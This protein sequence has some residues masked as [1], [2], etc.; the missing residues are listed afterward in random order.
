MPSPP[1]MSTSLETE[2]VPNV[3][4][5][6]TPSC[7]RTLDLNYNIYTTS[8]HIIALESN[9][10]PI[11]LLHSEAMSIAT[12]IFSRSPSRFTTIAPDDN[13][14][15]RSI[16]TAKKKAITVDG[17][18]LCYTAETL[19]DPPTLS[20][21]TREALEQLVKDWTS[22]SFVTIEGVG[23]PLCLWK[24]V[25]SW[26]RPRVWD[27]IKDQ[28][29]KFKF[30]VGGYKSFS[31]PEQFWEAMSLPTTAS[32]GRRINFTSICNILRDLR[33]ERDETDAALAKEEYS[34]EFEALFTYKKR[35]KQY[36]L[37]K[38]PDVARRYRLLKGITD[39][40]WD[41][42]DQDTDNEE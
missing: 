28:W 23:I 18:T 5:P 21:K 40:Y 36:M 22:S 1:S 4:T 3:S 15:S 42:D 26:T 32:P 33:K 37:K 25:Y 38:A 10:K 16:S 9:G 17:V 24:R 30:I 20:Y 39:V 14:D 27:R 6:I 8:R 35:G 13:S 19:P 41:K 12:S 11:D 31:S 2:T 29:G 34:N 7:S